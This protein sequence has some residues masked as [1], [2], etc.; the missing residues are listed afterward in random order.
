MKDGKKWAG[1]LMAGTLSVWLPSSARAATEPL[2]LLGVQRGPQL[3]KV[4]TEQLREQLLERGEQVLA[5]GGLSEADRKCRRQQCASDL[6]Q[7]HKAVL[8]LSADVTTTGPNRNLRVQINLFDQR[9]RGTPEA[10]AG[11]ENLCL[12]CDETKLALM[13]AGSAHEL[14]SAYRK[15]AGD[16]STGGTGET[17]VPGTV[18]GPLS[19][20]PSTQP[21]APMPT[22]GT[23][24]PR[25]GPALPTQSPVGPGQAIDPGV[26]TVAPWGPGAVQ[27]GPPVLAPRPGQAI[28]PGT[29]TVAP[30]GPGAVT[31][32]GQ[33]PVYP[34]NVPPLGPAANGQGRQGTTPETSR[35]AKGLS[36]TRKIL[37]GVLGGGGGAALI[38][39]AVF[40]G[41]DRRLVPG[42]AYGPDGAAC[43]SAE[44]V[45]KTCVLSTVGA[46]APSYALGALMLGGMVLTLTIPDNKPGPSVA[47]SD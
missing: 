26:G 25:T 39:G 17:A 16:S 10:L 43:R 13:V 9:R 38:L 7:K 37:A 21:P 4:A 44:N 34:V 11:I 41:L 36:Q 1:L 47:V 2:L 15:S 14:L 42:G 28:D 6:A 46:Y 8:L 5:V 30:W 3:D 31:T 18:A 40:H 32:A 24:I 19:S 20:L 45:G 29:G 35:K 23:P 33:A 27:S 22:A 12:D